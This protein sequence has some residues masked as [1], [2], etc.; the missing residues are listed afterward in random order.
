MLCE[1]SGA[2]DT[3]QSHIEDSQLVDNNVS[4]LSHTILCVY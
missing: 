2:L 1:L 3:L 4:T